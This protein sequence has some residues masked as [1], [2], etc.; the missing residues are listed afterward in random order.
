MFRSFVR[1]RHGVAAIISSRAAAPAAS[2]HRAAALDFC[3][4]DAG[5]TCIEHNKNN[6]NEDKGNDDKRMESR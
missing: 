6:N 1:L 5:E 2:P 3:A 4:Q